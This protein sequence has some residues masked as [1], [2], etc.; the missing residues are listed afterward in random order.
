M[1]ILTI[2]GSLRKG[3]VNT[4]ICSAVADLV[5][6]GVTVT[7]FALDG[8]P[9]FN[10]DLVRPE[11]VDALL[12]AVE[13]ADAVFLCTPEYNYSMSGVLKNALDW[14]SRPAY[15][16]VFKDKPVALASASPSPLGGA[17]AQQH[18]RSVMAAMLSPVYAAPEFCVGGA[19]GKVTDGELTDV[20]TRERLGVMLTGFV[21]F[22][23]KLA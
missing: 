17:R 22:S 5:P 12:T 6:D 4:A 11:A 14:A 23:R 2:S 7:S 13:S 19:F 16:S 18:L 8:V 9:L 15:A 20:D 10:S 3:S 21:E 1:N